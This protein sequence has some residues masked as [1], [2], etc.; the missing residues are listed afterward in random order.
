MRRKDREITDFDKMLAIM[1]QC[2]C[3]RL[4]FKDGDSV[5]IVPVNFGYEEKNGKLT[6]YF[7]GAKTGKKIDL[8]KAQ[9]QPHIGFEMDT[10][11]ELTTHKIACGY[12]YLYQSILGEGDISLIE[13][14]SEK[15]SA[16][17]CI[18]SHYS[19]KTEWD[20]KEEMADSVAVIKLEVTAWSCKAHG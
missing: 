6:L 15:L 5:Y 8:I 7:H 1:E 12:S 17:Q 16:L 9:P 18:M 4:G 13:N 14:T 2:D 11:H 19:G 10:K 20:F 3:C